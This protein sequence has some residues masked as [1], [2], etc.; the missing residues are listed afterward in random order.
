MASRST[1]GLLGRADTDEPRR[2]SSIRLA[3]ERLEDRIMLSVSGIVP[4]GNQAI[5]GTT[6]EK[7]QSKVW[8]YGGNWW[9]VFSDTADTYVWRLDGTA[10]TRALKVSSDEAVQADV[11][12]SGNNVHALL[13]KG[14]STELVSL[15]HVA[16]P[17]P[18]YQVWSSRPTPVSL[19]LT[20][21]TET[22]TIDIDST[23][24]MWMT[25]ETGGNI[26]VRH[27]DGPYSTWSSPFVL[28]SGVNADDISVV[29]AL[30]N[31]TIGVLW[32]NQTTERFGF[33]IHVD[34]ASPTVWSADEVPASGSAID[35]AAGM[36][37]DHLNIAVADNGTLYA[38]I[39]T[40]YDTT[41]FTRIGLLV[42]RPNGV[43]DPLYTVDDA[44]G[45]RPIVKLNEAE[46]TVLVIYR[47]ISP[48]GIVY[49]ESSASTIAFGPKVMLISGSSINDPSSAEAPFTDDL[50][51][52]AS[53]A[54]VV[55]GVKII[56]G[57]GENQP[58][59]VDAGINQSISLAN[60]L[61]LHGT[62]SDDGQPV[63]PALTTQWTVVT[64]PGSVSFANA[65]AV[66]TTATFRRCGHVRIAP[67]G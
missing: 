20:G 2:N 53:R 43:W 65:A 67:D 26:V 41:G 1:D 25:Y 62:V 35:L 19:P 18:T 6:G 60:V 56:S 42:R 57:T 11:E 38:A 44:D 3:Y 51:V 58:P 33:R 61:T 36:A 52:L 10:W 27:S 32:S 4:L 37:D 28:A 30:P 55:Q 24:R 45:T 9:A 54:G 7:P 16:G 12:V 34:G 63:P 21:D 23:G 13:F 39:K 49:R 8:E 15:E 64:G 5:T 31:N 29:T 40:G 48:A 59:V 14:A 46:N 66:D 50:V 17:T 22:A 47:T